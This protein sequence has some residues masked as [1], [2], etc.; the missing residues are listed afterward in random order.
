MI[1]SLDSQHQPRHPEC[2]IWKLPSE[3]IIHILHFAALGIPPPL[4]YCTRK[5]L[6]QTISSFKEYFKPLHAVQ[7]RATGMYI[8]T[9]FSKFDQRELY[10][11]FE[12]PD[13]PIA[14][15]A[16]GYSHSIIL[17]G[18]PSLPPHSLLHSLTSLS[19]MMGKFTHG[20]VKHNLDRWDINRSP[21]LL[22]HCRYPIWRK[23]SA[24]FMPEHILLS[25]F[26]TQIHINKW[27]FPFIRERFQQQIRTITYVYGEKHSGFYLFTD[28]HR[29]PEVG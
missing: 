29:L 13:K 27:L 22:N 17:T 14:Q 2:Q 25:S 20:D 23:V 7:L 9:K 26:M 6:S 16:T 18:S 11:G 10:K 15:L 1:H 24:E 28:V 3:V 4:L 19:Q 5:S 12:L 8:R 21:R